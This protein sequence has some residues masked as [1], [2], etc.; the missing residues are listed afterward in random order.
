VGAVLCCVVFEET[1]LV[2]VRCFIDDAKKE[3]LH[4]LHEGLYLLKCQKGSI[5]VVIDGVLAE[6]TF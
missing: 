6:I 3:C 5:A 4:F 1:M 2:K